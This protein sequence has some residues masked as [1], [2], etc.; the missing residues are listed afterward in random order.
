[1]HCCRR[2]RERNPLHLHPLLSCT[3]RSFFRCLEPLSRTL[4]LR[5]IRSALMHFSNTDVQTR[6]YV[7]SSAAVCSRPTNSSSTLQWSW[8]PHPFLCKFMLSL[9]ANQ[10]V[11]QPHCLSVLLLFCCYLQPFEEQLKHVAVVMDA[12]SFFMRVHALI[13]CQSNRA[14]T[15]LPLCPS[16]LLLLS[17]AV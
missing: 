12:T 15:S 14:S 10:T 2:I 11:P 8:M 4:P 6:N 3:A 13:A 17:A 1:M 7:F 5:V 16:P 9:H